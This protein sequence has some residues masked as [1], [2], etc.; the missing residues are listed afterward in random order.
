MGWTHP[1]L[2]GKSAKFYEDKIK[3]SED[4]I[5]ELQAVIKACKEE[6]AKING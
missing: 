2:Y 4:K 5:F 6:L 1:P 3:K